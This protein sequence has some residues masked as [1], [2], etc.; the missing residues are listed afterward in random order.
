[1]FFC[2]CCC[3]SLRLKLVIKRE[4]LD[5]LLFRKT[6]KLNLFNENVRIIS[7]FF[8]HF[9]KIIF[10]IDRLPFY[11]CCYVKYADNIH[12]HTILITRKRV[13]S[14]DK[15]WRKNKIHVTEETEEERN[16]KEDRTNCTSKWLI[17]EYSAIVNK[18]FMRLA[19]HVRPACIV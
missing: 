17:R 8:P 5:W 14:N 18:P 16:K 15:R 7:L 1:M 11:C 12:S 3:S 13:E 10:E 6:V 4:P 19:H 2:Y 9:D